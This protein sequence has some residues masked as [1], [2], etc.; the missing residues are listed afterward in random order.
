M[1]TVLL[2]GCGYYVLPSPFLR[3]MTTLDSCYPNLEAPDTLHM[4]LEH[5]LGSSLSRSLWLKTPHRKGSSALH[6]ETSQRQ[7]QRQAHRQ[8]ALERN[9]CLWESVSADLQT[10]KLAKPKNQLITKVP[11]N[12]LCHLPGP[13]LPVQPLCCLCYFHL[14]WFLLSGGRKW[15]V[16]ATNS[17]T[18]ST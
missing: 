7:W 11:F 4:P 17:N 3:H 15:Q 18:V 8:G 5:E 10:C 2:G 9:E 16:Q 6:V 13:R 1:L 14:L 12:L